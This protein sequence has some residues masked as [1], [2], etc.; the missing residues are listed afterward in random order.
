MPD[1]KEVPVEV[2][3]NI[4]SMFGKDVVIVVSVDNDHS[5]THTTTFGVSADD[6]TVAANL[7]EMMTTLTGSDVSQARW[8]SDFRTAGGAGMIAAERERQVTGEGWTTDHD[9]EHAD[10][11]M[12]AAALMYA[13]EGTHYEASIEGI[14]PWDDKWWKPTDKIRNL[15]KAGALIA[16]EIDRLKRADG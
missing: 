9:D 15:V 6:K 5:M 8:Y 7:G 3:M 2:A 1:Y 10:E 4:S 14:W 16:A 11:S 12:V 13:S